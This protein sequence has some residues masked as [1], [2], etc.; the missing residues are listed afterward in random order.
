MNAKETVKAI[1]ELKLN[2]EEKVEVNLDEVDEAE[3][4]NGEK[5]NS[6]QDRPSPNALV[7][8]LMDSRLVFKTISGVTP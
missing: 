1:A 2:E 7:R 4:D 5:S 8:Q 6:K 3:V